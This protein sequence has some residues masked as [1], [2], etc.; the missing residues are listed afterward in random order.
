LRYKIFFEPGRFLPKDE[1]LEAL[2]ITENQPEVWQGL[3]ANTLAF[4][5][6]GS[7]I[8]TLQFSFAISSAATLG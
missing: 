3:P 1:K 6:A 8:Q 7:S 4:A 5:V 2:T